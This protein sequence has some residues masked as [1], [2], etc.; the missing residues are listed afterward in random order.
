RPRRTGPAEDLLPA[1]LSH[2]GFLQR[3]GR[4]AGSPGHAGELRQGRRYAEGNGSEGTHPRA[5]RYLDGEPCEEAG[6][7]AGVLG[8]RGTRQRRRPQTRGRPLAPHSPVSSPNA[9]PLFL[10]AL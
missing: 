4:A 2:D 3:G 1:V 5:R 7:E 10:P 8:R 9:P 6:E